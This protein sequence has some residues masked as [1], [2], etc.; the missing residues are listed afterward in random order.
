MVVDEA[1]ARAESVKHLGVFLPRGTEPG[2]CHGQISILGSADIKQL[3]EQEGT[4]IE[5]L[6]ACQ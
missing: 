2:S 4:Q 3:L 6:I 5:A 1:K